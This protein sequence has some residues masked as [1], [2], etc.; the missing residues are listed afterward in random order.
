MI[1]SKSNLTTQFRV[2]RKTCDIDA[3]VVWRDPNLWR[4]VELHR[5]F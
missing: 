1:Y 2:K 5:W 4:S 3:L